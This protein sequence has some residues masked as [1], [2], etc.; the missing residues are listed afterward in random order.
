MGMNDKPLVP[1]KEVSNFFY[2]NK[3]YEFSQKKLSVADRSQ[4]KEMAETSPEAKYG[5]GRVLLSLEYLE[6]LSSVVLE[7]KDQD[8]ENLGKR[9][10]LEHG[11][12]ILF[13]IVLTLIFSVSGYY[14]ISLFLGLSS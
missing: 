4:M 8:Y 3:L 5:I 6:Q 9:T 2:E 13:F 12:N 1:N 10:K 14:L 7:I 11:I